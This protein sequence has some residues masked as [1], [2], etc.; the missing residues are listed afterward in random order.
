MQLSKYATW[1]EQVAASS[2]YILHTLSFSHIVNIVTWAVDIIF[3][4]EITRDCTIRFC[5]EVQKV[6]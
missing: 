2:F 4:P 6:N 1:F 5:S 3:D